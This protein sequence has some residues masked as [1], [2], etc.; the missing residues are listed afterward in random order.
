MHAPLA[1]MTI[2]G[3]GCIPDVFRGGVRNLG[4]GCYTFG[5]IP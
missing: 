4:S 2:F 3:P 5:G 1:A